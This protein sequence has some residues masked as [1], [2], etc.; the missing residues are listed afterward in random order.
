MSK[1]RAPTA[2]LS[3]WMVYQ[4]LLL[5]VKP[6]RCASAAGVIGGSMCSRSRTLAATWLEPGPQSRLPFAER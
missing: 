5:S 4:R 1:Q 3:I 2:G 6:C